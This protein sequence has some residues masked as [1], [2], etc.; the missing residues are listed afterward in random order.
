MRL[1]ARET[2]DVTG[3]PVLH[4]DDVLVTVLDRGTV[5]V[6]RVPGDTTAPIGLEDFAVVL[7]GRLVV[8]GFDVADDVLVATAA[9]TEL[10]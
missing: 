4:G 5:G 2:V 9:T 3:T 8:S 10:P 6:R 7:G 1:T